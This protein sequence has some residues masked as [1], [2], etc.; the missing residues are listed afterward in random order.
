MTI[1]IT[2]I[3]HHNPPAAR[4]TYYFLI[5]CGLIW[6]LFLLSHSTTASAL[7]QP[8]AKQIDH[9]DQS[10]IRKLQ[11]ESERYGRL[12]NISKRKDKEEKETAVAIYGII[13]NKPAEPLFERSGVEKSQSCRTSCIGHQHIIF[14]RYH[15]Q[16]EAISAY[17]GEQRHHIMA[18]S[19][20]IRSIVQSLRPECTREPVGRLWFSNFRKLQIEKLSW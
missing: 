5:A 19:I 11:E 9:A 17:R 12:I 4:S 8:L 6:W 2:T 1:I 14:Y 16:P 18:K 10:A 20:N 3:P 15:D 7:I 13:G